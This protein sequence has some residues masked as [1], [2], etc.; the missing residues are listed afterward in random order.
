MID[1]RTLVYPDPTQKNI[2]ITGANSGI[3]FETAKF[4]ASKKAN[5]FLCSRNIQKGEKAKAEILTAYPQAT[6]EVV[7][8]DLSDIGS[9]EQAAITIQNK[10]DRIDILCNN[11]GIMAVPYGKTKDGFESQIGVN[12]LGHYVLTGL[13]FE[14]LDDSSRIVN[15]SSKAYLQGNVDPDDFMF[16]KGGYSP[17]KSYARSKLSNVLFTL[18]LS[19]RI[20]MAGKNIIVVAAHPGVA[21]TGLFDRDKQNT[22]LTNMFNLFGRFLATAEHGAKAIIT[23]CI[24]PDANSG[25]YYGPHRS[26][27]NQGNLIKLEKLNKIASDQT[28]QAFLWEYSKNQT[29]IVYP[30]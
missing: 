6:I 2:V 13:L 18:E 8:L 29:N 1:F 24:D 22:I 7:Q 16:E 17:F 5:V 25:N 10:V 20:Q 14:K 15:V 21:K 3:G 27:A 4:F 9:I 26:K 12:H 23:A 19:K 28:H 11:A 30:I